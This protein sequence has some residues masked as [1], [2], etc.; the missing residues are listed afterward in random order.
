M[1]RP[2][3]RLCVI[4]VGLI[5]GS[6]ARALRERGLVQE[7]VGCGRS[8]PNLE[9]A[10]RMGV[11]DRFALN[12]AEAVQGAVFVLVQKIYLKPVFDWA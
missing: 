3:R 1:T 12:P 11:V 7:V 8:R 9:E 4:G 6:F 10:K 5:G 2:V